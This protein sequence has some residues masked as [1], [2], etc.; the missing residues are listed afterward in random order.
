MFNSSSLPRQ[1]NG[2]AF[3]GEKLKQE[4]ENFAISEPNKIAQY[5][6]HYLLANDRWPHEERLEMLSCEHLPSG[7]SRP[8]EID[9][10]E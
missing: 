5:F 2:P 10:G 1:F 6:C 7:L 9:Y 4:L 8:F 3:W